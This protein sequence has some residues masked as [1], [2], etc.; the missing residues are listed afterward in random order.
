MSYSWRVYR[1][2]AQARR[3][4]LASGVGLVGIQAPH[5]SPIKGLVEPVGCIEDYST[6]RKL[7]RAYLRRTKV[8]R[9]RKIEGA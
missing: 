1:D 8:G 5:G 2:S 4:C 9:Y 7:Q 3:N 6:R